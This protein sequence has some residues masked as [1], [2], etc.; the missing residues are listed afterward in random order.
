MSG[1]A[2]APRSSPVLAPAGPASPRVAMVIQSF[3]PVLGGAER[4]LERLVPRLAARGADVVVLTRRHPGT[5]AEELVGGVRVRRIAGAPPERAAGA[6]FV[7]GA[8]AAVRSL[9]PDVVHAHDLLSPALVGLAGGALSGVPVVVKPLSAGPSGDV[10]RLLGKPLGRARLHAMARRFAAFVCVSDEIARELREHGVPADRCVRIPNGVDLD[11]FRPRTGDGERREVRARLGVP[12]DPPLLV[13]CGRL[14]A[15]KRLEVLVGALPSVDAHLLLAGEGP[16]RAALERRAAELG[17]AGRVHVLATVDD[18]APLLRAADVFVSASEQDGLS[19][20]ALEAM[21]CGL[22]LV[23][24]GGA[25][26][27]AELCGGGAGVLVGERSP[28]AFAAVLAARLAEPGWVEGAGR[29]ARRRAEEGFSIDATAGSLLAL[30]DRVR[31]RA[32]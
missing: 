28:D 5:A 31:R 6:R 15:P 25:G 32:P 30:Y 3:R 8:T 2:A 16:E 17:V 4:Q 27:M 21:A 13:S 18:P 1:V 20:A 23:A 11:H 9:A 19:N 10:A 14:T 12:G 24:A 29:A 22:P 26:G 7:A